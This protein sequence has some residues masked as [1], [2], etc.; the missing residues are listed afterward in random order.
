[1]TM[2]VC[3][4]CNSTVPVGGVMPSLVCARK[5]CVHWEDGN[6]NRMKV[7]LDEFGKCV[8]YRYR[9]RD[10]DESQGRDG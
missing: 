2:F 8:E 9:G 3:P 6:C 4:N 5:F 7:R 10:E 1:M